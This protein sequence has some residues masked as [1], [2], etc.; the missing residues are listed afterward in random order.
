MV[1]GYADLAPILI[2]LIKYTLFAFGR[3]NIIPQDSHVFLTL[4]P[5]VS[6]SSWANITN[7]IASN[8][9]M[10]DIYTTERANETEYEE[11]DSRMI[12]LTNTTVIRWVNN[13][14][15]L[16]NLIG[17]FGLFAIFTLG[18]LLVFFLFPRRLK[19]SFW[20][21]FIRLCILSYYTLT[22]L[23]ILYMF[24]DSTNSAMYFIAG[25]L[26]FFNT[27]CLPIYSYIAIKMKRNHLTDVL[28]R[29][30]IGCMYLQYIPT[31]YYFTTIIL[32]KQA[33]YSMSFV[34]GHVQLISRPV[35][36]SIQA[37]INSCFFASLLYYKPYI[38][39][40]HQM[41]S[42]S[43]TVVKYF[44]LITSAILYARESEREFSYLIILLNGVIF[45]INL[46]IFIVPYLPFMKW[47]IKQKIKNKMCNK[48]SVTLSSSNINS[49]QANSSLPR[50]VITDYI[51]NT[52]SS[53]ELKEIELRGIQD[54][55]ST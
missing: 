37:L 36:I 52:S 11:D 24:S 34:F 44:I 20:N 26:L 46:I 8:M 51:Y 1:F 3:F 30:R 49:Y 50:W 10:S 38:E 12:G 53:R 47:K 27:I 15:L 33:L 17:M 18:Y 39:Q 21:Y 28:I 6:N 9:L 48:D 54:R 23:S 42:V 2:T 13:H 19:I 29:D 55:E 35:A 25:T 40:R 31:C 45:L 22:N 41:Q 32:V 16:S 14:I 7:Y 5:V 43:I 4:N